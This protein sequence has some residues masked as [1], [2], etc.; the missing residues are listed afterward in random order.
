MSE[1]KNINKT[2][3][4]EH[5]IFKNMMVT[6]FAVASLFLLKNLIGKT[7]KGAVVIGVCLIVFSVVVFAMKKRKMS[8][9]RQQFV[10]CTCIV[11]LVFCI[12]INSGSYYSDDFPLY[13][14]VIGISG[15]YLVP[16]YTLIQTILIDIILIISYIIHPE[17]ADPLSQ[18]IMCVVILTICAYTFYLTIK[19]GRAYIEIGNARA[20][21]AEKLLYELK[22]AGEELQHNCDGSVQRIAKLAEANEQLETNAAHMQLESAGITQGTVEMVQAFGDVQEKMQQTEKQIDLLNV[23]VKKVEESLEDNKQNMQEMTDGMEELKDAVTTAG[24]VF[25]ALQE[26]IFEISQ[27]TEQLTKIA[28]STNMLALNASI[29][30]ARA[31][32]SGAGFAVVASKVQELAE[33][34]NSCSSQVVTVVNAMQKRIEETTIQMSDSAEAINVSIESLKGFQK[35]FDNLMVHFGS[36]YH[37]IEEQNRNVQQMD[38]IFENLKG[39]ISEMTESSEANQNS[40]TAITDTINIYKENIDMVIRDNKLINE[41]SASLLERSN[42]QMLLDDEIV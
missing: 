28:A 10:M 15:L 7:W 11:F 14:A 16:R 3:A 42:E 33:D 13:L 36:L 32:Q 5:V 18:Y 38:S 8:Q 2:P 34:S 27:V 25:S 40:V 23:E 17:K 6:V 31:G 9:N 35:N 21:E 37:N 24:K 19:R 29:E 4:S 26:E 41:L 1:Q 22:N 30:A 20:E 39:K 12:S